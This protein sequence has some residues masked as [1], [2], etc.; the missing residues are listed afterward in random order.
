MYAAEHQPDQQGRDA[1]RVNAV[2]R[3]LDIVEYEWPPSCHDDGICTIFSAPRGAIAH[4]ATD[5]STIV[6]T[7][8][9]MFH[10][11]NVVS[12]IGIV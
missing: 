1:R 8:A 10:H 9:E 5:T 7:A 6:A 12:L 4:S 2:G 3:S 11:E